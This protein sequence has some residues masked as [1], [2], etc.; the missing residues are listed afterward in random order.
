MSVSSLD[1]RSL[2][3]SVDMVAKEIIAKFATQRRGVA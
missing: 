1:Q 3:E 2:D